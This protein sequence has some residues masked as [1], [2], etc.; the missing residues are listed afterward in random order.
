MAGGKRFSHSGADG[1]VVYNFGA[2]L[3]T[4]V[5]APLRVCIVEVQPGEM[6]K[7][8]PQIGDSVRV[9]IAPAV[10]G[11]G[12]QTTPSIVL[13]PQLAGLDTNLLITTDRR[14]YYSHVI[15]ERDIQIA[16]Q[17]LARYL[18]GKT[19]VVTEIVTNKPSAERGLDGKG[20]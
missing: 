9:N 18:E 17:N 4:V 19:K 5:C 11:N 20:Q 3:P 14:A 6:L 13:K 15:D 12:D 1:R 8:E 2:G 10:Y 7:G 16:G